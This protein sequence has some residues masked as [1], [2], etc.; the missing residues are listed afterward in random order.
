MARRGE[1]AQKI[2]GLMADCRT[3]LREV[4]ATEQAVA[5]TINEAREIEASGQNV[6]VRLQDLLQRQISLITQLDLERAKRLALCEELLEASLRPNHG[7]DVGEI[8]NCF[9]DDRL[10][11]VPGI[12]ERGQAPADFFPSPEPQK[13]GS[14]TGPVAG[15]GSAS[16]LSTAG[17]PKTSTPAS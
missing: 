2:R 16:S 11:G 9:S 1:H 3:C 17:Q 7:D 8:M 12:L 6:T 14:I 15:T 13:S 5:I 4:T 10:V